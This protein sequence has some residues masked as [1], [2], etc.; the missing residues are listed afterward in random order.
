MIQLFSGLFS[1]YYNLEKFKMETVIVKKMGLTDFSDI[2]ELQKILLNAVVQH[3]DK[4]YLIFTE[5]KPVITLGKTAN[6]KNLL[7]DAEYLKS[8]DIQLFQIDRGGDITF[9]GPGQ[10]VGYPILNLTNF[11]KDI[12]WYLRSLEEVVIQTLIFLNIP[13]ERMNG[14]T[15]VWVNNRKICA[16]GIKTSHWV[17][18]HGFALNINLPLDYFKYIIPCGLNDKGVTSIAKEIHN[19]IPVETVSTLLL[20]N[21]SKIFT[22]KLNGI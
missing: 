15:G 14:L 10:L 19:D 4:H 8:K 17:T 22:V 21:F 1:Q 3:R 11:K 18:M 2:W 20:K 16:I 7:Y 6:L 13:A 12:H 5:H 9:H